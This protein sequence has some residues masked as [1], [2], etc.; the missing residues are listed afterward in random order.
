MLPSATQQEMNHRGH[1]VEYSTE[2]HSVF[3]ADESLSPSAGVYKC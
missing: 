3:I 1:I 2:F